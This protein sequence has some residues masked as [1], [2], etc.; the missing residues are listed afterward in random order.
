M[1]AIDGVNPDGTDGNPRL[2]EQ[3]GN[4]S[5]TQGSN[6]EGSNPEG[7]NPIENPDS[8]LN[9]NPGAKQQMYRVAILV[10]KV[11]TRIAIRQKVAICKKVAT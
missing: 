11:T 8:N 10:H 6:P 2:G 5:L 9:L 4:P 7:S 1:V 3:G